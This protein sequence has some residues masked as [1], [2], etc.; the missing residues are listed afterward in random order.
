M[1]TE[2]HAER[3]DSRRSDLAV[4]DVEEY[5]QKRR[6]KRILDAHDKVEE[7]DDEGMYRYMNQ[8]I[9]KDGW[10]M[11]LLRAVQEY[12]RECFNLVRQYHVESDGDTDHYWTGDRNDPLGKIERQHASDVVFYGLR[13]VLHADLYYEDSW[14]EEL[15]TRHGPNQTEEHRQQYAVPREVSWNAFL[16]LNEFLEEEMDMDLSFEK[17]GKD[18]A[19]EYE[20]LLETGPP[21][22]SGSAPE[23]AT[24]GRGD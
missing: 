2:E 24:D 17:T 12:I 8:E 11:L 5:K 13:D 1:S 23:I 4:M 3:E 16:R 10:R 18:S 9:Q 14:T 22:G 19:F 20:D 15:R 21:G 6:I 7:F